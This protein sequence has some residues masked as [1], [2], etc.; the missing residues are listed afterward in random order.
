MSN[1][2]GIT[3]GNLLAT[4]PYAL[5]GSTSISALGDA[6]ADVLARRPEEISRLLIYPR[7][8]ELP[9]DLLDILAY[10]FKV[11]WW[12]PNYSLEEKRRVFKGSWYVHKHL[13]TKAAVETAI[14]AIYPLTIVEEW[15]EYGGEPYHFRLNINITSDSGDRVRQRRVLER[16]EFYKSLRSHNDGVRYF[17]MPEKSWAVAGGLLAGSREIDRASVAVPVHMLKRPGGETAVLAGGGLAGTRSEARAEVKTPALIKPGGKTIVVTGGVFTGSRSADRVEIKVTP[18]KRP[19][20]GICISTGGAFTGYRRRIDME[21]DVPPLA[22]PQGTAARAAS[23]GYIGSIE[24]VT[25]NLDTSRA[26]PPTGRAATAGTAGVFH[27]Y[28]RIRVS[29]GNPAIK[30]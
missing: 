28:R 17:L 6:T 27:S 24:R 8:D 25:V 20:A 15:F 19:G 29:V 3:K 7:I 11:D 21:M 26:K 4:F 30:I 16:L 14:R 13:G 2:N 5:Q 22:R 23:T 10:D 12:D 1:A 9:E 18:L